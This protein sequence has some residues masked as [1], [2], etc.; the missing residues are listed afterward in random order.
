MDV[1]VLFLCHLDHLFIPREDSRF[2]AN[3][4]VE[5]R[6]VRKRQSP[7]CPFLKELEDFLYKPLLLKLLNI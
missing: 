5:N 3:T 6:T 4:L 2:V 7:K 1:Y